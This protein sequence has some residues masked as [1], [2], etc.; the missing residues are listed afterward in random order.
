MTKEEKSWILYDVGNSAFV[1]IIVTTIMPIFFKDI[2]SKGI[3]D[4]LSTAN[5]GFANSLASLVL[6]VLA[7][8]LGSIADFQYLKK[9]FFVFFL[10]VGLIFTV[11]LTFSGPGAWIY[12][13][14]VYI[15]SRVGWAGANIFYD[16]FIVDVTEKK[17]MDVISTR[18][19]AY[20][21]I[22][23]VFPFLIVIAIIM[24]WPGG[25]NTTAIHP[26]PAKIGFLI[27]AV[28]WLLFSLPMLKNVRHKYYMPGSATPVK[29]G[30]IKLLN[31]FKE[32][33]K[34]KQAFVFL[35]AYFF[36]IDGVDTII[37]MSTAYGMDIGLNTTML[38]LA[39]LMIQIAAFPFTL[40]FGAL[41][42][43]YSAKSMIFVG[44]G[45]FSLITLIAFF[46]PDISNLTL[47][48]I[49]F[50]GLAF[51]AAT[52]M[53]GIQAL[54]R[55][56]FGKLI[57]AER[58]AEFFGFYNIFGKFAAILG[59]LIM[60]M[61]TRL[62]GHSRFGILGILVLFITGGLLLHSVKEPDVKGQKQMKT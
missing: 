57:P 7:P 42:D 48:T 49:A 8:I 15:F 17:S 5:W 13:L 9:R 60:G 3:P 14:L 50:W 11:L 55:S 21:Y 16:A 30:F 12:C 10:C 31:T 59:P 22:G 51:L 44:I 20:G 54:S 34:F 53:G 62:T 24:L 52:S 33:R 41:A 46:L 39:I 45:V 25:E 2:A 27:A 29:D 6:A 23:S 35:I 56:Y 40:L 26:T 61:L 1:L 37:S 43:R 47:R 32:I 38:I 58:S 36:Y 18:G 28:W 4:A 19:Y